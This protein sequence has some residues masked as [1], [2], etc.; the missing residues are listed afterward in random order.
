MSVFIY[1]TGTTSSWKLFSFISLGEGSTEPPTVLDHTCC[2]VLE[3]TLQLL[4]DT[5]Q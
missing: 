4:L 1:L 5:R 2:P 3:E